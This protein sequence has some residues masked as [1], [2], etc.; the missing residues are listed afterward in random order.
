MK[1]RVLTAVALAAIALALVAEWQLQRK[2][3][4]QRAA[5][6]LQEDELVLSSG[7]VL[8]R[9]SLEYAPL[10]G[11]IYWTRAVQYYGNK[12]VARDPNLEQL[13]PLLDISTTLDPNLIVAYRFGSIFL[14]DAPPQGAGHP[15]LAVKLL[16]RGLKANPDEWRLYQDLG[17]VYYFDVK[18]YQKASEAF[19]E[20]SKNPNAMIWM[21]I[22][23]AKIAQEGESMETSYFL[24][25]EVY[26][27]ST[28]AQIKRNAEVHLRALTVD[29]DRREIDRRA[30]EFEKV[31]GRRPAQ[32][33]DLIVL[34]F[35][36]EKPRDPAG[37]PYALGNGGRAELSPNSPMR[38]EYL[39]GKK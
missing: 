31:T 2:L 29:L 36:R 32:M 11:A 30:D 18:N 3:D 16:E 12:H 39:A 10:M 15:E 22:M 13:W 24:W 37:Y 38:E 34:G 27:G 6:R 33:D 20:G 17:T 28:D 21:K 7:P 26:D 14:G 1:N 4:G 19:L 35:L 8:R 9:L 5:A 25:K 23:A